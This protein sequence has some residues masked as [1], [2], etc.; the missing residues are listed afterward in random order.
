MSTRSPLPGF[1]SELPTGYYL[2][3]FRTLLD[4]VEARYDDLLT[5][6][7]KAFGHRFR[8]LPLAGQRLFVRLSSRKGPVFR[9]DRLSYEEIPEISGVWGNLV[10][11]GFLSVDDPVF[12][13]EAFSLLTSAELRDLGE[14]LGVL[15]WPSPPGKAGLQDLLRNSRSR[16][17]IG[18]G[19]KKRFHWLAPLFQDVLR[20]FRLLFFG[21]SETDLTAFVLS[22][23]GKVR[24]EPYPLLSSHRLFTSRG[25]IDAAISIRDLRDE[26]TEVISGMPPGD[27]EPQVDRLIGELPPS[28]GHPL[29][30]RRKRRFLE[31]AGRFWERRGNPG[32][33]LEVYSDPETLP[34]RERRARLL[35]RMGRN[36]EALGIC[37]EILAAPRDPEEEEVAEG[38]SRRLSREKPGGNLWEPV[39]EHVTLDWRGAAVHGGRRARSSPGWQS[40]FGPVRVETSVLEY[41]AQR[42]RPGFEAE[43]RFWTGIFGLAFWDLIF[44]PVPRAF[45]HPFQAGPADLFT[46]EFRVAR[47]GEI[48]KRLREIGEDPGWPGRLLEIFDRKHGIANSLVNWDA[49][50][51]GNIEG[52]LGVVPRA[53][54][55]AVFDRLSRNPG[56]F[57]TGFPDLFLFVSE[58]P[59]YL[60]AEVKSPGDRLQLNQKSWLRYFALHGI[61]ARLVQVEYSDPGAF[62][63]Q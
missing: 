35:A 40:F 59:G 21:T 20:V 56:G 27:A 31:E 52:V 12:S 58:P 8:S 47:E 30:I 50:T 28:N 14:H 6:R 18:E 44:L 3:H 7:E 17:E 15:E 13:E 22:D 9:S 26:L 4:V 16:E 48:R 11:E 61:P 39:V 41:F 1:P 5:D 38:L 24:F 42:G 10:E 57:K 25:E 49:L 54:L 63:E 33:A 51:R 29:L 32:C 55:T 23:L 37:G 19:L 45:G 46:A 2:E 36:A 62:G 43:N 60:L 34:S 53:H